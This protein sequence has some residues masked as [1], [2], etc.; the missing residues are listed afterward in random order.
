MQ[1]K[2]LDR[3]KLAVCGCN[4]FAWLPG[5][6]DA[7]ILAMFETRILPAFLFLGMAAFAGSA[8]SQSPGSEQPV[9]KPVAARTPYSPFKD[10]HVD[11]DCHL[12]PDPAYRDAAGKSRTCAG[13]R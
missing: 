1:A 2:R 6:A 10:I 9:A 5:L 11:Q 4:H 3:R 8:W 12:L 7:R 13:I